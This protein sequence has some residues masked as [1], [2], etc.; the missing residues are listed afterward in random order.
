MHPTS[1]PAA[2][3]HILDE[4]L[5]DST[6]ALMVIRAAGCPACDT[7]ASLAERLAAEYAGRLTLVVIDA[8]AAPG[9]LQ[10]IGMARLPGLVFV[11]GGRELARLSGGVPEPAL[12]SWLDYTI[13]GGVQPPVPHGP[14]S[15]VHSL[16]AAAAPAIRPNYDDF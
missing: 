11:R 9:L 2:G 4:L 7:T 14:S 1:H 13:H 3:A 8:G 10:R 16:L 5:A 15:H 6:P 12:R